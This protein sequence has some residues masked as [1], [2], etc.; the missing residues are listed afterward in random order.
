MNRCFSYFIQ[1]YL[2]LKLH[3][4]NSM[5]RMLTRYRLT[6]HFRYC[7]VKLLFSY[8]YLLKDSKVT[9]ALKKGVQFQAEFHKHVQF[10]SIASN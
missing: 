3:L 10:Y 2:N 8:F 7:E 6:I 1:L 9:N 5:K 4:K